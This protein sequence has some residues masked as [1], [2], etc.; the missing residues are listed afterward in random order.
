MVDNAIDTIWDTV[1]KQHQQ[2]CK[3]ECSICLDTFTAGDEIAWAKDGSSTCVAAGC[4]HIFH[5][6]C[7][8][9]WLQH[10][11]ECPLCRRLLVHADADV[12]FA[13]W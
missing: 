4:D 3:I 7:L 9:S 2:Q 5:R 11:D 6:E 1:G 8:V 10:H 12:R 13:G